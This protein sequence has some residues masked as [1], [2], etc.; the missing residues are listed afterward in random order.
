[1]QFSKIVN[2]SVRFGAVFRYAESYGAVRCCDNSYGAVRCGSPLNGLNYGAWPIPVRKTVQKRFFSTVHRKNKPYKTAVSYVSQA[3]SRGT[4]ET[5][6]SLR[7][8]VC[9]KRTKRGF[10]RFLTLILGALTH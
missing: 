4:N 2:A 5:A 7:R 6:V 3:F 1:M 8:T 10:V 9:I